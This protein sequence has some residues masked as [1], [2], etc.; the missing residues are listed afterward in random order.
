MS[1]V[2]YCQVSTTADSQEAATQLA[3]SAVESRFAACGQVVGPITSVYRWEGSI[4]NAVEWLVL[5][6]TTIDRST[7]LIEYVR[8][9]HSYAV[10]EIIVTPLTGGNPGYLAWV[11]E[12]SHSS[13]EIPG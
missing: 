6:K 13:A 3:R 5:F 1:E 9:H 11:A 7:A 12:E 8:S 4:E 10:P 2:E